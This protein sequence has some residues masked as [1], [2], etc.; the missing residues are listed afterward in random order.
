MSEFVKFEDLKVDEKYDIFTPDCDGIP[1]ESPFIWE[2]VMVEGNSAVFRAL[3][4]DYEP[5]GLEVFMDYESFLYKPHSAPLLTDES[6]GKFYTDG[7]YKEKFVGKFTT[8]SGL[9]LFVMQVEND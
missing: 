3:N 5:V 4:I 7:I 9:D 2:A 6:R 1:Q 8:E